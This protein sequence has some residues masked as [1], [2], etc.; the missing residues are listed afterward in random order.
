MKN[1]GDG[2]N[3]EEVEWNYIFLFC[4]KMIFNKNFYFNF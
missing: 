2:E 1:E 4:L 3:N